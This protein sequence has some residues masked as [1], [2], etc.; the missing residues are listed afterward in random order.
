M[1]M[2][3]FL[4]LFQN[5]LPQLSVL[6]TLSISCSIL[7]VFLVLRNMAMLANSISH[8]VLLGIVAAWWLEKEFFGGTTPSFALLI[9]ASAAVSF[10]TILSTHFFHH[11]LHLQ[12]DASIGLVF[13]GFFALGVMFLS[14]AFPHSHIGIEIIMGNADA[15]GW[16]DFLPVLGSFL[17]NVATFTFLQKEYRITS[18]DPQLASAMGFKPLLLDFL[19]MSLF[20]LT[21]MVGF[22]AVGSFLVLAFLVGPALCARKLTVSLKSLLL[23]AALI[24][25]CSAISATFGARLLLEYS[26]VAV[27][28]AGLACTLLLLTFITISLVIKWK[29]FKFIQQFWNQN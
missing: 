11:T 10:L 29:S 25:G 13:S 17:L 14:L 18:F 26:M 8:T 19:L 2:D 20:T 21:V 12:E 22:R 5:D 16:N 3:N 23:L 28:T 9:I 4:L 15:I 24:G 7:G 1:I 27:S 6:V